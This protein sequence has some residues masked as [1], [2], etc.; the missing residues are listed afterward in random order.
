MLFCCCSKYMKS[1]RK[2]APRRVAFTWIGDENNVSNC[3]NAC[4]V[5]IQFLFFQVFFDFSPSC[6]IRAWRERCSVTIYINL[7][8]NKKVYLTSW[9]RVYLNL[10]FYKKANNQTSW[11][12]A[13]FTLTSRSSGKLIPKLSASVNASLERLDKEIY[14]ESEIAIYTTHRA[15]MLWHWSTRRHQLVPWRPFNGPPCG[16]L[17]DQLGT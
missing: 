9:S 17:I 7:R 16:L 2:R 4:T 6:W 10:K 11:S 3:T 5:F 14:L 13:I 15:V 8:F 12:K 1:I